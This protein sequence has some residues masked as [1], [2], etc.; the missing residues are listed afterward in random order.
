MPQPL[1]PQPV[2]V[3][4]LALP[5]VAVAP[6]APVVNAVQHIAP[7]VM[8]PAIIPAIPAAPAIPP[9]PAAPV[10]VSAAPVAQPSSS[11]LLLHALVQQ[12]QQQ[13]LLW[14]QQLQIQPVA[15]PLPPVNLMTEEGEARRSWVRTRQL[16]VGPWADPTATP[17]LREFLSGVQSGA[18]QL[19]PSEARRWQLLAQ[20]YGHHLLFLASGAP[21]Q[22]GLPDALVTDWR[23]FLAECAAICMSFEERRLGLEVKSLGGL[24]MSMCCP[25]RTFD[26]RTV[27][28][29]KASPGVSAISLLCAAASTPATPNTTT[30]PSSNLSHHGNSATN[31]YHGNSN[32]NGYHGGNSNNNSYK[33]PRENKICSFCG[34]QGHIV[35]ECRKRAAAA[36][37]EARAGAT[38][39]TPAAA[40]A[41]SVKAERP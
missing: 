38:P 6:A 16:Y 40:G 36:A 39:Q 31:G 11:D 13:M 30:A 17:H 35:E 3:A 29:V 9:I 41:S 25:E 27:S 33:R 1:V 21:L 37:A 34:N 5:A 32:N 10:A 7:P 26:S 22:P 4:A 23:T 15:A 2:M 20:L 14:Q 8:A 24:A 18:F 28:A 19:A 12:S